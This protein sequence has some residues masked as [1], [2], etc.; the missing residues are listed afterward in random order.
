M[1]TSEEHIVAELKGNVFCCY[2]VFRSIQGF[3]KA[4]EELNV[5]HADISTQLRILFEKGCKA[6]AA[7]SS[8]SPS[9]KELWAARL[10]SALR[11]NK[12]ICKGYL[13][14]RLKIL[15]Y[16]RKSVSYGVSSTRLVAREEKSRCL[17]KMC[18]IWRRIPRTSRLMLKCC[19]CGILTRPKWFQRR[20]RTLWRN[21]L[22]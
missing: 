9:Q 4:T 1:K 22:G 5:G 11:R 12:W 13:V 19:E 18:D 15:F 8:A 17:L 3:L 20:M 16:V 7:S 10:E 6:K 2:G 21:L 14:V